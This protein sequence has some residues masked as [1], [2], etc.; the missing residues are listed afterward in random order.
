MTSRTDVRNLTNDDISIGIGLGPRSLRDERWLTSAA[1]NYPELRTCSIEEEPR[2][3]RLRR[4]PAS[5]YRQ[6][7]D[8]RYRPART[9]FSSACRKDR[10]RP[11]A[12]SSFVMTIEYPIEGDRVICVNR[13]NRLASN[14][15]WT[16]GSAAKKM[17]WPAHAASR[18]TAYEEKPRRRL[19]TFGLIFSD[20]RTCSHASSLTVGTQ[21]ALRRPP[22]FI[23]RIGAGHNGGRGREHQLCLQDRGQCQ[24]CM[25]RGP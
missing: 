24:V 8:P 4:W 23:Q 2:R 10:P 7:R 21:Q 3:V 17:P 1:R 6:E 20:R 25:G 9:C 16:K 18:A 14:S 12:A 15:R 5:S 13:A 19:A 11:V 22:R